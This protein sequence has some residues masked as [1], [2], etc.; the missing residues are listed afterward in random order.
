MNNS[1]DRRTGTGRGCDVTTNPGGTRKPDNL[2]KGIRNPITQNP[3]N[4]FKGIRDLVQN[5]TQPVAERVNRTNL[6]LTVAN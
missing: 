1:K 2:L 6:G 4:P 3:D 5:G